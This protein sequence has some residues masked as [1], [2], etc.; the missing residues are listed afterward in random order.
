[1]SCWRSLRPF[2]ATASPRETASSSL[3]GDIGW[4]R[5]L[6][7]LSD[8]PGLAARISGALTTSR[9][10]H[11]ISGAVAMTAYRVVRATRDVDVLF[12]VEDIRLPV[13]FEALRKLGFE[14]EDR[15][16]VSALRD[17]YSAEMKSGAVAVDLLVP[18]L[19]YHR[20]LIDR[21]VFMEVEGEQVPFVSLEDL[22]LLK[23]LWRRARDVADIQALVAAA[24]ALDAEYLR[25]TLRGIVPGD[26]G[27]I[28]ELDELLK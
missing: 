24:P 16:L 9:I 28:D 21:A 11:A 20:T 4:I 1:V 25:A 10:P 6:A 14:G 17:R 3:S 2:S 18:V 13:V 7:A 26:D 27:R 12:V 19:P 15:E 23:L 8:L 22:I 5:V